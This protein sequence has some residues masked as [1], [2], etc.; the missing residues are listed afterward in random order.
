MEN[1]NKFINYTLHIKEVNESLYNTLLFGTIIIVALLT[2]ILFR[3]LS[4]KKCPSC[5]KLIGRRE[6]VL[7]TNGAD[8]VYYCK[9]CNKSYYKDY[10]TNILGGLTEKL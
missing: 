4:S 10:S 1:L 7:N 9:K 3:F 8:F 5:R 6:S 2:T